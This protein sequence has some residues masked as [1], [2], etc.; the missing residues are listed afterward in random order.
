MKI[1]PLEEGA[2]KSFRNKYLALILI[3]LSF[4]FNAHAQWIKP[5]NGYGTISNRQNVKTVLLFPTGCGTPAALNSA[6]SAQLGWAIYGDSCNN[7]A[8]LYNPATKAWSEIAGGSGSTTDTALISQ[9]VHD[10]LSLYGY[11]KDQVDSITTILITDIAGKQDTGTHTIFYFKA[12]LIG[13]DT[14][15]GVISSLDN[16]NMPELR[17]SSTNRDTTN[18]KDSTLIDKGF[19]NDRLAAFTPAGGGGGGTTA[20]STQT[21]TEGQTDF[22]FTG[23]PA[24]EADYDIYVNGCYINSSFYTVSGTTIT[25]NNGLQDG[26]IVDYARKK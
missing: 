4:S 26:S 24:D 15:N 11:S 19:L 17:Y 8:Y 9:I 3:I 22:T 7:K 6:D 5:N 18:W 21:S 20:K 16:L 13:T 12:P 2:I 10:S 1:K 25:F 14:T 23:L